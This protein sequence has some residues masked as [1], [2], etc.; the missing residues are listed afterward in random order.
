[1][2]SSL[3]KL[4]SPHVTA[5]EILKFSGVADKLP[6]QLLQKSLGCLSVIGETKNA[7]VDFRN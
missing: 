5:A 6:Y 7:P 4:Y 2:C 1:M 3:G